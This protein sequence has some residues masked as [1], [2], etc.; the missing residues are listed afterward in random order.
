MNNAPFYK[1]IYEEVLASIKAG[2]SIK[3]FYDDRGENISRHIMRFANNVSFEQ[4]LDLGCGLGQVAFSLSPKCKNVIAADISRDAMKIVAVVTKDRKVRAIDCVLLD[5]RHLPFKN[6]SFDLIVSSGL[7]EW[8]PIN[9]VSSKSPDKVQLDVLREVRR[10]LKRL[11]VFWLGI[12]N[13]YA[14]EYFLGVTD[15][16]SGLRFVTFMPRFIANYYSKLVKKQ[17]YKTYLYNYWELRKILLSAGLCIGKFLVGFPGYSNP[18]Q[19]ADLFNHSEIARVGMLHAL[20]LSRSPTLSLARAALIKAISTLR[21]SKIFSNSFIVLCTIPDAR[22]S[23]K[24][25]SGRDIRK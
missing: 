19:V 25:I 15:H 16:H 5:S 23:G 6:N 10:A 1:R 13:R 20:E 12:E 4:A 9:D 2:K 8:T 11:G 3:H 17:P 7:L 24:A 22:D 21:L 14:C 18:K